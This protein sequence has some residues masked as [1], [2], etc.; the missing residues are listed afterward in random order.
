MATKGRPPGFVMSDAH[1]TKISNS[2]IL[3][4]LIDCAEGEVDMT[5][6]QATVALGLLRKVMPDLQATQLSGSGD[7]GE[8]VVTF[9]TVYE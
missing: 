6:T 5:P 3:K 4:R 2:K 9:K 7:N 8:H 1:R